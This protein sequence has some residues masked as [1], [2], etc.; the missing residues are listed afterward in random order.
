MSGLS[1]V[2][3]VLSALHRAWKTAAGLSGVLV[4]DGPLVQAADVPVRLLFV[5]D[6]GESPVAATSDLSDDGLGG[7]AETVDVLCSIEVWDA[8]P[9]MAARRREAFA[10]LAAADRA[11][12]A[13]DTLAGAVARARIRGGLT[14]GQ[15]Q[16]DEG[17]GAAISFVVRCQAFA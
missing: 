14:Y 10:V 2:P 9:D 4:N 17:C 5:G 8:D 6:D 16:T 1:A 15:M 3:A 7:T 11:L 13:D 12:Q